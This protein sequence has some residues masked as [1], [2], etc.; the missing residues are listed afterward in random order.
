MNKNKLLYEAPTAETLVV[1][2]EG[3]VM[4][5]ASPGVEIPNLTRG[6]YANEDEIELI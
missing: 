3:N 1:R 2:F 6:G 4:Q 5:V